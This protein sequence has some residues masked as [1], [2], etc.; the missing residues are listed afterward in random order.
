MLL[1]ERYFVHE[2][3][4]YCRAHY[5]DIAGERCAKCNLVVDGGLRA[6]GRVWHEECLR[7]AESDRPLAVGTAYLHEGQPVAPDARLV[8]APRCHACGEA[9]VV[10][11]VYAHGC[12]YHDECFRCVHCRVLI[13]ERKYVVFDGEPYLDGCY[14]KLF[15]SS[16]GDAMRTQVHGAKRRYAIS[17]P[18]LLSLG[19]SALNDFRSKH[20]EM[21][22]AVRRLVRE[23]GIVELT[24]FLFQPPA[25]SKPSLLLSMLI[26]ATLEADE[27]LPGL[28]A[29]DRVGQQWQ[30]LLTGAHDAAAVR[31]RPWWE[32]ITKELG[33]DQPSAGGAEKEN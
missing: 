1:G 27:A 18:L 13:G 21:L 2:D 22:P 31:G 14:Q 5:L 15:G 12:V 24:S 23:A 11:R 6:L 29:A 26:P 28:L 9:A 25:V 8:T 33:V 20:E 17:V 19:A 16:A 7:C 30:D 32:N 10:G 3:A 4:P